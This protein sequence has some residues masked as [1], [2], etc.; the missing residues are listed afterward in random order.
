MGIDLRLAEDVVIEN[1]QIV[2]G[3]AGRGNVGEIRAEA[4]T[5]TLRKGAVIGSLASGSGKAAT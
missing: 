5:L 2:A 3:S 4:G 1:S